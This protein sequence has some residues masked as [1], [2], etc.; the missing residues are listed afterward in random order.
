M[1][2]PIVLILFIILIV[3]FIV[4]VSRSQIVMSLMPK[5]AGYWMLGGYSLLLLVSVVFYIVMPDETSSSAGFEEKKD[6]YDTDEIYRQVLNGN[7]EALDDDLQ[8][9]FWSFAVPEEPLIIN[10]MGGGEDEV[11]IYVEKV[12]GLEGIQAYYYQT[13]L[14]VQDVRIDREWKPYVSMEN[15]ML[16][17]ESMIDEVLEYKTF[18]TPAIISQTMD[19]RREPWM[20]KFAGL[21]IEVPADLEIEADEHMYHQVN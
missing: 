14:I 9:G 7:R 1:I 8:K 2:M 6:L 17:V 5:K 20:G 10:S 15:G 3:S 13:P 4:Y 18:K 11:T 16:R 12:E 19:D 21:Y